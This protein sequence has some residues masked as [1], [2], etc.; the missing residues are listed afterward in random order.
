MADIIEFGFVTIITYVTIRVSHFIY[1]VMKVHY[2]LW[3]TH[4]KLKRGE[5]SFES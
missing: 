5:C 2:K 1:L 4:H 3:K